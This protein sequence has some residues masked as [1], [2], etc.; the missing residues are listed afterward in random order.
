M[1]K[2]ITE[3]TR[4]ELLADLAR[5]YGLPPLGPDE[6][7]VEMLIAESKGTIVTR[8]G[9]TRALARAVSDGILAPPE[10]RAGPNGRRLKAWRRLK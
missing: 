10:E 9:A 3:P 2:S 5:A 1:P 4:S 6:I 8:M 7:T